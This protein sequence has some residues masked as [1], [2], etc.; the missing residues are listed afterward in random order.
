LAPTSEE[1]A[2]LRDAQLGFAADWAAEQEGAFLVVG[3]LNAS[4]WSWPFRRLV[5][6]GSLRNSQIGFGLQPSFPA[7]SN[8]LLRVPIDHLL[9]SDALIVTNRRL[10]EPLGSDHFPLLVDLAYAG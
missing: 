4:P 7:T 6:D 3:D 2:G 9:H 10:G 5:A 8:V 1:R